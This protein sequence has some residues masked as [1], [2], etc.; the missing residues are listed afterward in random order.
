MIVHREEIGVW[1]GLD[2]DVDLFFGVGLHC[3]LLGEMC[4]CG[5]GGERLGLGLQGVHDDDDDDY[6]FAWSVLDEGR[7]VSRKFPMFLTKVERGRSGRESEKRSCLY[8]EPSKQ[9]NK[10]QDKAKRTANSRQTLN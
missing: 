9:V 4:V 7:R 2:I 5:A 10:R 8:M 1:C 6:L 3:G